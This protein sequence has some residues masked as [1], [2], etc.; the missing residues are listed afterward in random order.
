MS[1]IIIY[2]VIIYIF[3]NVQKSDKSRKGEKVKKV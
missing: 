3:L 2:L 1:P